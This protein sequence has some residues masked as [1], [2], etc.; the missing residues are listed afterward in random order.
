[1][2][3][4]DPSFRAQWALHNEG[5]VLDGSPVA[6][7]HDVD[8]DAPEAWDIAP[9]NPAGLSIEVAVLD[10]EVYHHRDLDGVLDDARHH[11]FTPRAS[12]RDFQLH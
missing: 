5:L 9:T 1:M 8:I 12:A 2:I 3:P 6:V 11:R 10:L 4:D 7:R